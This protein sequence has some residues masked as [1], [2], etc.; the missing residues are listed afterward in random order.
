[1]TKQAQLPDAIPKLTGF[2]TAMRAALRDEL[3]TNKDEYVLERFLKITNKGGTITGENNIR[4]NQG[5]RQL[6]ST[7][8][9]AESYQG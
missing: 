5:D 7:S 3:K 1:M 8:K 9:R 2:I 4:I 6:R